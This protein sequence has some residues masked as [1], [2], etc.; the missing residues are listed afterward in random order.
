MDLFS[1][2]LV[3]RLLPTYINDEKQLKNSD[4]FLKQN[5]AGKRRTSIPMI[6]PTKR[7]CIEEPLK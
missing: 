6:T 3:I 7:L 5:I 4:L 1:C 2:V